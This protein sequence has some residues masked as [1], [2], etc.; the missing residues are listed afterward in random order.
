LR[1]AR[2][3]DLPAEHTSYRGLRH[4]RAVFSAVIAPTPSG[5]VACRRP[6]LRVSRC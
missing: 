5:V 6:R 1:K 3:A 2:Y 4:R